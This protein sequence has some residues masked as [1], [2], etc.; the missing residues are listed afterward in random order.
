MPSAQDIFNELVK[1]GAKLDA[2]NAT[3]QAIQADDDQIVQ[4][5]AYADTALYQNDL[6]NA[7]I[8]CLLEQIAKNTCDLVNQS[9]LQTSYQEA[10]EKATTRLSALF[11]A[12]HQEA[13][14]ILEREDQL[15]KEIE[16]CCPPKPPTPPCQQKPC[17]VPKLIGPP[18]G[19]TRQGG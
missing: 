4:L 10:I 12:T 8:I 7:T 19:G 6:Q 14:F 2:I 9:A 16:K 15:R 13:A 17:P 18:P 3:S 5:M 1:L 11:A